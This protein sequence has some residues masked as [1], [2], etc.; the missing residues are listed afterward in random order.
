M[1]CMSAVKQ[2][3]AERIQ[4]LRLQMVIHSAIYYVLNDN[5]ISD[6]EWSTRAKELVRLQEEYPEVASQVIYADEFKDFDGS[7]GFNLPQDDRV[8]AKAQYLLR[9]R[10]KRRCQ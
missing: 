10:S 5:I 6:N 8:M 7:T 4:Q 2:T 9:I 3:I 1:V